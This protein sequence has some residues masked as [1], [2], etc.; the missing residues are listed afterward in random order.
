M[1]TL[2]KGASWSDTNTVLSLM[3]ECHGVIYNGACYTL[4]TDP[5]PWKEANATCE[6]LNTHLVKIE[7]EDE[8]TFIRKNVLKKRESVIGLDSMT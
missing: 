5:V 8:N 2:I 7:S 3:S 1:T 6:A 4:F